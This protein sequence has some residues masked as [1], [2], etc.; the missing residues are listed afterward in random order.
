M[1]RRIPNTKPCL[2]PQV[3]FPVPVELVG[4]ADTFGESGT[5]DDLFKKYHLTKDDIINSVKKIIKRK[6]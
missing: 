4:V 3:N 5:A 6:L 2:K 1:K